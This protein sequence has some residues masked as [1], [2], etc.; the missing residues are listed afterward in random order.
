MYA[1]IGI[2]LAFFALLLT[3]IGVASMLGGEWLLI[4]QGLVQFMPYVVVFGL[5]FFILIAL[6]GRR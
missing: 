3:F 2:G 1:L 6:M 4:S 5:A